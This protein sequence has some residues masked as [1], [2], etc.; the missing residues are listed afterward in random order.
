MKWIKKVYFILCL[1]IISNSCEFINPEFS[2]TLRKKIG[3]YEKYSF[4]YQAKESQMA[5]I[6][7][8]W[9]KI[10]KGM[11][12]KEVFEILGKP[13]CIDTG[14]YPFISDVRNWYWYYSIRQKFSS[15]LQDDGDSIFRVKISPDGIVTDI[16]RINIDKKGSVEGFD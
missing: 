15:P 11:K 12:D 3:C 16:F 14:T 5:S 7:G 10:Q 4:P 13:D 8:N 1:I 9:K 2:D 6:L